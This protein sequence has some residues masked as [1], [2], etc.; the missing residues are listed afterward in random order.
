MAESQEDF[1]SKLIRLNEEGFSVLY[2]SLLLRHGKATSADREYINRL[3]EAA[4][5][6]KNNGNT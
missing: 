3:Y 5:G 1:K 6:E 2:T 4:F